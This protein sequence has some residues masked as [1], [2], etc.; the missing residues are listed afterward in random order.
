MRPLKSCTG[1]S[2]VELEHDEYSTDFK[3]L[4]LGLKKC[5]FGQSYIVIGQGKRIQPGCNSLLPL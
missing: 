1:E 4:I 2:Q 5:D 3:A